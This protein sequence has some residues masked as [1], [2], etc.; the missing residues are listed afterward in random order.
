[1]RL[2][3][4]L[5]RE[6]LMARI[7]LSRQEIWTVLCWAGDPAEEKVPQS[8]NTE[9]ASVIR[10]LRRALDEENERLKERAAANKRDHEQK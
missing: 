6:V 4:P 2:H 7:E 5:L 1:M 3:L 9:E 8:Y 10:K